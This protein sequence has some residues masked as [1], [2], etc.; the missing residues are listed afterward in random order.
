[1]NGPPFLALENVFTPEQL[2]QIKKTVLDRG[3]QEEDMSKCFGKRSD[4]YWFDEWNELPYVAHLRDGCI[5]HVERIW[6]YDLWPRYVSAFLYNV[7]KDG[8]QYPWHIDTAMPDETSCD[9]K[10]TLVVNTSTEPYEGG[11]L[12]VATHSV[13]NTHIEHMD[14][15]GNAIVFRSHC[16]HRVEPVTS[17]ERSSITMFLPGPKWR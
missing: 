13:R 11:A 9:T 15:P 14:T 1:M 5:S 2:L 4:A 3:Q 12:H 8:G 6:G 17:G 16:L 7:Y 10:V